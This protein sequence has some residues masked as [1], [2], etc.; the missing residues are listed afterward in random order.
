MWVYLLFWPYLPL[1]SSFS[2]HQMVNIEQVSYIMTVDHTVFT[3]K[4]PQHPTC[5]YGAMQTGHAGMTMT[6]TMMMPHHATTASLVFFWDWEFIFYL[7]WD[8]STLRLDHQYVIMSFYLF[9]HVL[10][11]FV[12]IFYGAPFAQ[13]IFWVPDIRGDVRYMS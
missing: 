8:Q 9:I 5:P 13:K 11:S 7:I 4:P 6:M 3:N 1:I 12:D 2:W 10:T